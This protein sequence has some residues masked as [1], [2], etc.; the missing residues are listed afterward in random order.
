VTTTL[1]QL[2]DKDVTIEGVARNAHAGAVVVTE[3]RTPVYV[4]G[5]ERWD[6]AVDGKKVNAKG[7]LRHRAPDDVVGA[8]GEISHGFAGGQWVLEAPTWTVA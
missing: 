7:T 3:D 4:D 5:L 2:V 6:R 8:N 1:T